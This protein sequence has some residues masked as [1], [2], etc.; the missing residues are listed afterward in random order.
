MT[1]G[2]IRAFTHRIKEVDLYLTP[3]GRFKFPLGER[4][5]ALARL[6][7]GMILKDGV[8]VL[9]TVDD[10]DDGGGDAA[11]EGQGDEDTV[12]GD[13]TL[14]G[15]GQTAG[16][17]I[18]PID[19]RPFL[20]PDLRGQGGYTD[21]GRWCGPHAGSS[22]PPHI[23]EQ[24]WRSIYSSSEK[25]GAIRDYLRKL[26]TGSYEPA[27]GPAAAAASGGLAA[28]GRKR[29]KKNTYKSNTT[30]AGAYN[31]IAYLPLHIV[32]LEDG[33][34][35]DWGDALRKL[36]GNEGEH[37]RTFDLLKTPACNIINELDQLNILVVLHAT[38]L[39]PPL[40]SCRD[41]A[42]TYLHEAD[43]IL[44]HTAKLGGSSVLI[45]SPSG[46]LRFTAKLA[47]L[48]VDYHWED[49]YRTYDPANPQ[50][51]G[52]LMIQTNNTAVRYNMYGFR[53]PMTIPA[54][55]A[56]LAPSDAAYLS[57]LAGMLLRG[58]QQ[59][60]AVSKRVL[61]ELM[62]ADPND[63]SRLQ[64]LVK[65]DVRQAMQV[66]RKRKT[67]TPAVPTSN[68]VG[69]GLAAPAHTVVDWVN[70]VSIGVSGGQA[71]SAHI[72]PAEAQLGFVSHEWT[73]PDSTPVGYPCPT[74]TELRSK[75]RERDVS[76]IVL[77]MFAVA[78]KVPRGEWGSEECQ[79]ALKAEMT[80]QLSAPW[81]K[82]P[83]RN[84]T[85]KGCGTWD[86]SKVCEESDLIAWSRKEGI[87][88]HIARGCVLLYE[89]GSELP[90]GHDDRKMRART[91][92]LGDNVV[93]AW[94]QQAEM[95]GLGSAPP[96]M[97]DNRALDVK[98][99]QPGYEQSDADAESAYLQEWL[100]SKHPTWFHPPREF[101]PKEWVGKYRKPVTPLTLALYGHTDSGGYWKEK[102]YGDAAAVGW[103]LVQDR[104]GFFTCQNWTPS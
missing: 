34:R 66:P 72:L 62:Q 93:D 30:S 78:R 95:E 98:S 32:V 33:P 91:V 53:D 83:K 38:A 45:T 43:K 14:Q 58:A 54:V 96:A 90:K 24:I 48:T 20:Q 28:A 80:K 100:K 21:S 15:E 55:D 69:G 75:H 81:P 73:E 4:K 2:H 56:E 74:E 51:L 76:K 26:R 12:Y 88:I 86:N 84:P 70:D 5:E 13:E 8:G 61:T 3:E 29:G 23:D 99:L 50:N 101:W 19:N 60:H 25:R 40:S 44:R 68:S 22:K 94:F 52:R 64:K 63:D 104:R 27:V 35:D 85:G 77:P 37:V 57:D 9:D 46:P 92:L 47:K 89:K 65:E 1:Y 79:E 18:G 36:C 11:V 10:P 59:H 87:T 97:E 49:V 42:R 16:L 41:L 82:C 7:P 102:S 71:A 103:Q 39:R 17:T 67:A 6:P 31:A